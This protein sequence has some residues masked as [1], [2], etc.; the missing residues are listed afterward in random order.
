MKI[1]EVWKTKRRL[2]QVTAGVLLV[3][4]LALSHLYK[5]QLLSL[6]TDEPP[7]LQ[8]TPPPCDLNRSSCALPIMTPV[9]SEAPWTF[10]ISPHPIPVSAPLVFTLTPPERVLPTNKPDAIWVDLSGDSMDM[11]LIRIQLQQQSD[12]QWIGTGS[13]PICITGAMRWRARVHMALE[14]TTLQA[15]WIFTA[16]ESATTH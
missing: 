1:S 6:V 14:K 10:S 7:S 4:S 15:D 3:L 13:I 16:P 12:G 11:G 5:A 2:W 9:A 8:I